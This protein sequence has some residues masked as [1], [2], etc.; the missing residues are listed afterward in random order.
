[1]CTYN[2]ILSLQFKHKWTQRNVATDPTRGDGCN[3]TEGQLQHSFKL[4]NTIIIGL[5]WLFFVNRK[6]NI[7]FVL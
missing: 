1:M 7:N 6:V 3:G 2:I 5:I 4:I